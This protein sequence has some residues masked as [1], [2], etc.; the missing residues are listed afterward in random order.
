MDSN[1]R[2]RLFSRN[3]AD[4]CDFPFSA[5]GTRLNASSPGRSDPQAIRELP[6]LHP[7]TAQDQRA[8]FTVLGNIIVAVN[9]FLLPATRLRGRRP[10]T[11]ILT[12]PDRRLSGASSSLR[13]KNR[14]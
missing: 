10:S 1:P 12:A 7:A 3:W 8:G 4:F 13:A 9:S 2:F 6:V 5:P 14:R 11:I